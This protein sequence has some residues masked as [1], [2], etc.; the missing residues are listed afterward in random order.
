MSEGIAEAAHAAGVAEATAEHALLDAT[1]AVETAES[2]EQTAQT[3]VD[4]ASNAA[5]TAW[6][7]QAAV[8]ELREE[9]TAGLAALG[10]RID[11]LTEG[12]RQPPAGETS[13]TDEG[14]SRAPAKK[15]GKKPAEDGTN[16]TSS[17]PKRKGWWDR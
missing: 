11:E 6:D 3:A 14:A 13:A 12:I 5:G 8:G 15:S 9:V 4:V 10:M 17:S 7:A 1:E 16:G 2:A